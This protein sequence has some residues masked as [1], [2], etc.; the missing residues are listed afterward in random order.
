MTKSVSDKMLKS[1]K[2][3]KISK[4]LM[5]VMIKV[6]M[7]SIFICLISVFLPQMLEKILVLVRAKMYSKFMQGLGLALHLPYLTTTV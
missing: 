1:P 5:K 4:T 6:M 3:I 2:M 7:K